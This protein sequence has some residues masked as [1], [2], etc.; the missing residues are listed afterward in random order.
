MA[1][2]FGDTKVAAR[3]LRLLAETFES[4]S[5]DFLRTCGTS[6]IQVAGD[7]GC[8]VGCRHA[9]AGRS[10]AGSTGRW[11]RQLETSDRRGS[12]S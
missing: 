6:R 10:V 1:Y 3:R 8:G 11:V 7:L 12:G 9:T 4:S 2:T 5:R